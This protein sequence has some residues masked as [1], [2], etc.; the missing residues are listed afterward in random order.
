MKKGI[1]LKREGM[2]TEMN[3]EGRLH[4]NCGNF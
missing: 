3:D 4:T 1:A 2:D